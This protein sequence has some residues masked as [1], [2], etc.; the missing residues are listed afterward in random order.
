MV[1]RHERS[2]TATCLRSPSVTAL[3]R[4]IFSATQALFRSLRCGPDAPQNWTAHGPPS[5]TRANS[6]L[7]CAGYP[8]HNFEDLR[9]FA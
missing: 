2:R 9:N 3:E 4:R 7:S 6:M 1:I 8:Q 5:L